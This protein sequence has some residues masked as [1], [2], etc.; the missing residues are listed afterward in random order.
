MFKSLVALLDDCRGLG[1]ENNDGAAA[2]DDAG[3]EEEAAEEEAFGLE[4]NEKVVADL[5]DSV[6]AE[7]DALLLFVNENVGFGSAGIAAEGVGLVDDANA[8]LANG[9]LLGLAASFPAFVLLV[10]GMVVVGC[11]ASVVDA[12]GLVDTGGCR[13]VVA[14]AP[15]NFR[16]LK[17][18]Y[19]ENQVMSSYP[20]MTQH[21]ISRMI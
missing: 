20:Y 7:E 8:I 16:L 12:N 4:E 19:E 6:G 15:A 9:L 5:A 17:L 14:A 3:C 1:V 2:D 21:N 13:E 11:G 10:D 18:K